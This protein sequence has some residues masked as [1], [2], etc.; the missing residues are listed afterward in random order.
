VGE[1]VELRLD[2]IAHGGEAFGQDRGRVVFVPFAIPGERV[3][4]ELLEEKPRW[5]R[6]RL[7]E[8]LDPSPDR[9]DPPCPYFGPGKCSGCQ[10]QHIAYERQ[11]NLKQELVADQLRR[12]GHISEPP[13]PDVIVL[14]RPGVE[15]R[16]VTE[17]DV[18]SFGYRNQARFVVDAN[19][20]LGY[21]RA[22]THD[23]IPV[24]RC[25]LLHE[26][27][28]DLLGALDV[29]WPSMTGVTLRVGVATGQALVVL[30]TSDDEQPELEIDLPAACAVQTQRGIR[31]LVGEPRLEEQITGRL[32]WVSAESPFHAN[33][34]GAE[35]L[36]EVVASYLEPR[37][38]DCLLDAYCGV[39]LFALTLADSVEQVIGIEASPS[40]CEDF[41]HNAG[42]QGGITLHE[43]AIEAVLPVLREQSQPVDLVVMDPPLAGAGPEIAGQLAVLGP[44]RIVYVSSDPATLA[45]DSMY[46]AAAGYQLIEA[47]PVDMHPQTCQ[48]ETVAL[49]A[50]SKGA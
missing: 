29:V 12:L 28:D 4:V 45:R 2:G 3:R 36:V 46:F 9:I 22:M 18:L 33:T 49:W 7:I 31:P 32:F 35:A 17:A 42:A 20:K 8:I 25:L 38:T 11:A 6:A 30:E 27:L 5:A 50:R 1:R 39:G 19:G 37:K 41:A 43:G 44:R 10:W 24:D 15:E 34:T 13:V 26:R 23:V 21:R 48:V 14:A 40:A 47:Q 16:A